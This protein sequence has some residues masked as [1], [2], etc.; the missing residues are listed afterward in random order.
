M[1]ATRSLFVVTLVGA[2][3]C[4][5]SCVTDNPAAYDGI[6]GPE[7]E[8]PE[9]ATSGGGSAGTGGSGGT[10]AGS[11]G[12]AP[13]TGGTSGE[14]GMGEGGTTAQGGSA[15]SAGS[16][17]N[18]PPHPDFMPPCFAS[19]TGAGEEILKGVSC[20]STDPQTCYRPCGP[21]QVGWKLEECR[22]GVY[23]EED[24]RFPT[25]GDY[26]CY[27]LPD[28]PEDIDEAAC[29]LTA[30][31]A[32]RDECTAQVCM[33]CNF[34]GFYEDTGGDAKEGFCVCREPDET[35]VR[36][37]TC[38]SDTAWPCPTSAGCF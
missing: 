12:S 34:N 18:P 3:G 16:T 26:S 25:D 35:G 37:W 29:G 13:T 15:G 30:P 8:S 10:A 11:G 6:L 19:T 17:M 27:R 20:T 5:Q 1:L 28:N 36:R 31:P 33:A 23:A 2:F 24:C 9:E 4:L 14:G 21:A 32:A 22:A 38:A 7:R